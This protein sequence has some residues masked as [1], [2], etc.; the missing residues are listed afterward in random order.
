MLFG[1]LQLTSG[2]YLI[3]ICL[4]GHY[5]LNIAN[6]K[7]HSKLLI[8]TSIVVI[9]QILKTVCTE[10]CIK[11]VCIRSNYVVLFT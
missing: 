2:V 5:L 3:S 8:Y 11:Y 9:G 1:A 10:T 6:V 7:K 4:I